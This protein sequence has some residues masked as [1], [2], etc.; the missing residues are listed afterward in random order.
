[1]SKTPDDICR[2]EEDPTISLH[3]ETRNGAVV[4]RGDAK[5]LRFLA[6]IIEAQANCRGRGFGI[7]PKG[8]GRA[9]F[10]PESSLGIYLETTD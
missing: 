5:T 8:A 3:I 2:D 1:M 4:I 9:W 10:N 6:S 7:S